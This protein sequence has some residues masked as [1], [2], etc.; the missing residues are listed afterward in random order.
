MAESKTAWWLAVVGAVGAL[1]G[2]GITGAFNYFE[3]KSDLDAK[4]I[5]LSVSILRTAPAEGTEPLRA[6]AID[7]IE[8]RGQFKFSQPQQAVLLKKALPYTAS[9]SSLAA[10]IGTAVSNAIRSQQ[11]P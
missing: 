5:E 11:T 10:Q 4:M 1:A 9:N 8:K 2:A 7:V 3:H 6:W